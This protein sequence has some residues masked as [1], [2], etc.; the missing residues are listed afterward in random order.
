M[1]ENSADH[2]L[3]LVTRLRALQTSLVG[4]VLD[5]LGCKQQIL[6]A[7]IHAITPGLGLT[8]VAFPIRGEVASGTSVEATQLDGRKRTSSPSY[9][10]FRQLTPGCVAVVA[11]GGYR[12]AGP[13][14]ENTA[15]SARVRGCVGAVVDGPTRDSAELAE[16]GFPTFAR[17]ATA[18]RI[19][20]RWR[21]VEYGRPIEMPGQ[22]GP[23]VVAPGDLVL[24]DADGVMVVP[25]RIAQSAITAAEQLSEIETRMREELLAGTDREDVY[26]RHDRYAHVRALR[27]HP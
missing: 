27:S 7:E 11:T 5:E 6:D 20:G 19:E 10:F 1:N 25:A 9:E 23:V 2:V 17:F 18:A 22:I 4:D 3:S 26:R 16:M 14:G 12:V 24:G 21:H 15:L 8:G 13:W